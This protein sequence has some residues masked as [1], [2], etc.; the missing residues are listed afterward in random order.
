M[1]ILPNTDHYTEEDWEAVE[2]LLAEFRE[3]LIKAQRR[4]QRAEEMLN[5]H[6][7]GAELIASSIRIYE[8]ILKRR[9]E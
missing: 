9:A 8:T 6:R 1:I 3:D 7:A 2:R 4:V 5:E